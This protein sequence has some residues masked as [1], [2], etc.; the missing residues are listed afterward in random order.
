MRLEAMAQ[1]L[2]QLLKGRVAQS[3]WWAG[4]EFMAADLLSVFV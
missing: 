4:E 1:K 2:L 3:M